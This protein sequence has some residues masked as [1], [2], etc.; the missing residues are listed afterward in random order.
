[1]A[2]LQYKSIKAKLENGAEFVEAWV[3]IY[4]RDSALSRKGS[5]NVQ[6]QRVKIIL[7]PQYIINEN[8]RKQGKSYDRQ[9][10]YKSINDPIQF[11]AYNKDG[12]LLNKKIPFE[13]IGGNMT[14]NIF[15][16]REECINSYNDDVYKYIQKIEK[17][18]AEAVATFDRLLLE[19][20]EETM[21]DTDYIIEKLIRE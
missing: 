2:M 16:N 14:L 10:G 17:E 9:L 8:L 21:I 12:K 11:Q 5:R 3:S 1:M 4:C 15:D 7:N 18:K 13:G 19:L 20:K 6:P